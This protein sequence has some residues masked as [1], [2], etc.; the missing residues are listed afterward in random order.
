MAIDGLTTLTSVFQSDVS[1]SASARATR[2][3]VGPY[4]ANV[5]PAAAH[6]IDV[7]NRATGAYDGMVNPKKGIDPMDDESESY[8]LY[9]EEEEEEKEEENEDDGLFDWD[10]LEDEE[11][12]E[13]LE[14]DMEDYLTF[15][16]EKGMFVDIQA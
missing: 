12:D 11:W 8:P 10:D 15:K 6:D 3:S 2:T 13:D 1:L 4:G 9:V 14:D 7:E 5:V 16:Q